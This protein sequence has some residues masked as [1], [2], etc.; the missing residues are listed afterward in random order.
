MNQQT[1]DMVKKLSKTMRGITIITAAQ[2]SRPY[3]PTVTAPQYKGPVIVDY[4][5][6]LTK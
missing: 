4:V 5:N 3:T 6:L 2:P 1:R